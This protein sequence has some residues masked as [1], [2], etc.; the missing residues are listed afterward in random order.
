MVL[1]GTF[2]MREQKRVPEKF[3]LKFYILWGQFV[4]RNSLP[5]ITQ[6]GR[7]NY[8]ISFFN[9]PFYIF[10][11]LQNNIIYISENVNWGHIVFFTLRELIFAG[12]YFR[13]TNFRGTYFRVFWPFPQN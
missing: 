8:F 5:C 11:G 7:L 6:Y 13:G 9:T 12:T 3:V 10:I 4:S 2:C 1:M